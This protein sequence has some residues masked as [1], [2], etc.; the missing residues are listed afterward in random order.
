MFLMC[1]D[2]FYEWKYQIT[3]G[4]F[5]EFALLNLYNIYLKFDLISADFRLQ[6]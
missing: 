3:W 5:N 1:S 4:V 2:Y 6:G